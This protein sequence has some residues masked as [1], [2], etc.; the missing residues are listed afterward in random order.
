MN[1]TLI[2]WAPRPGVQ[3]LGRRIGFDVAVN[4]VVP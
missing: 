3:G 2:G 4:V 1:R